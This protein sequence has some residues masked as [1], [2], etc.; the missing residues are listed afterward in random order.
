MVNGRMTRSSFPDRSG[1]VGRFEVVAPDE[2]RYCVVLL[3]DG[4]IYRTEAHTGG[5]PGEPRMSCGAI[6]G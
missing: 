4:S 1:P 3:E 5:G 6:T 2:A